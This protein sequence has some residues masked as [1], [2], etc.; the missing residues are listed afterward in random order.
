PVRANSE[1]TGLGVSKAVDDS[2]YTYWSTDWTV[3]GFDKDTNP[4]Y[5]KADLGDTK[6]ISRILYTPRKFADGA[7]KSGD[8]NGVLTE[9]ELY[10][11]DDDADYTLIVKGDTGFNTAELKYESKTITFPA[12]NYRYIKLVARNNLNRIDTNWGYQFC[13]AELK[14]YSGGEDLTAQAKEKLQAVI[15]QLNGINNDT[16]KSRYIDKANALNA[17]D[18]VC[19]EEIERFVGSVPYIVTCDDYAE[20]GGADAVYFGRLIDNVNE[21]ECSSDAVQLL[22]SEIKAFSKTG[23]EVYEYQKKMFGNAFYD[24]NDEQKGM[25]LYARLNAA[26]AAAKAYL[27]DKQDADEYVMLNELIGYVSDSD[28]YGMN[29]EKCEYIVNDIF[30]ALDNLAKIDAGELDTRLNEIKSGELW[31][32]NKGSK[33]SAHGGQIITGADGKYYWYGEDNKLGYSLTTGLSCYSSSDLKD[34]TYEGIALSVRDAKTEQGRKFGA[35]FLTDNIIGSQ[36]RLERPKVIY[37]EKTKQYVMW[38]HMENKGGYGLSAA[39]VAV[40]DNPAGP[41]TW[42]WYGFPVWDKTVSYA[43]SREDRVKQTYRDCTLFVDEDGTAYTVY[44]SEE[45]DTTYAVRLN[46][47]YTWIDTGD[48]EIAENIT[49]TDGIYTDGTY[50]YVD[51]SDAEH[52][53]SGVYNYGLPSFTANQMYYTATDTQDYT[54]GIANEDGKWSRIIA[55]A[56]TAAREAPAMIYTGDKSAVKYQL[57]TSG[58]SGWYS[59]PCITFTSESVLSGMEE[60]DWTMCDQSDTE[61]AMSGPRSETYCSQST[62]ILKLPENAN[63]DY[64]YMGDRWGG[65]GD[66]F[67]SQLD[68]KASNYIWL[69]LKFGKTPDGYGK[70]GALYANW[71]ESW[72][73][74]DAST[75][76]PDDSDYKAEVTVSEDKKTVTADITVNKPED[77][78]ADVIFAAYDNNG[79]IV[80]T[81]IRSITGSE[82]LSFSIDKE[83]ST[84]KIFVWN[85]VNKMTPIKGNL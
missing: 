85:S 21:K 49:Y 37:N 50:N 59:N 82:E 71:L 73:I 52:I 32:D 69:P 30:F 6:E 19:A 25:T 57:I 8:I 83:Y 4:Y 16:V 9:Y 62:W 41:F 39:G 79:V 77:F 68:V 63:Y 56:K 31:L 15:E 81:Q 61:T 11:S 48:D 51:T 23:A 84:Y 67:G 53:A 72:D 58:T 2:A 5:I 78:S 70:D 75:A 74:G 42:L 27:E 12:V 64:V 14:A 13:C 34:W 10:G 54:A 47:D 24:M 40:A 38:G 28:A 35:D 20:N 1:R 43:V 3:S 46:S 65:N 80:S 36:G 33:I 17:S 18:T 7:V 44:S 22:I 55:R 76:E 29:A 26:V 66:Y 60:Q 45:N